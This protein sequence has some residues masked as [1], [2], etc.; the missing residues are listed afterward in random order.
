[1]TGGAVARPSGTTARK[2]ELEN[3]LRFELE[4]HIERGRC[5]YC[6]APAGPDRPLTR[7]HVIPRARGGRRNDHRI[8][9][10]ACLRCNSHRGCSELVPFLLTRPSRISSFLDYLGALS[11]DSLR[12][13]DPRIFAELYASIAILV[14]CAS[15]GVEWRRELA[16]L[17]SGRSLHRRR[18]AA[19][20][21]VWAIT[22]RF[23]NSDLDLDVRVR[24]AVSPPSTPSE[25]R[26][27]ELPIQLDEPIEQLAA[28][29]M[30]ILAILW[31]ISAERAE[32]EM[33]RALAGS[34][35]G[36]A[37]LDRTHP[38]GIVDESDVVA[39]DGWRAR[40]RRRRV[41]VDRRQGRMARPARGRAA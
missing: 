6:R 11:H 13:L 35:F 10:P 8:I 40:P 18:H 37:L 9:V 19:R 31:R 12:Q 1:M 32:R 20:R 39:L 26:S 2:K 30:G 21:A 24:P 34:P 7:E 28:R 22:E 38:E 16:R 41:R 36:D 27:M 5:V 17:S 33:L 15:P 29:V 25:P 14:E 4:R 23:G 3:T